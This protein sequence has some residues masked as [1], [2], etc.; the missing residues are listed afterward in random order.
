[1]NRNSKLSK[2][3]KLIITLVIVYFLVTS[4]MKLFSNNNHSDG[5]NSYIENHN[6]SYDTNTDSEVNYETLPEARNKFTKIIGNGNDEVTVMVYMIGTDL[7]SSYGMATTDVWEILNG[8]V[9]DNINVVLQTGGC[10]R[11]NNTVFD[12]RKVERWAINSSNFSRLGTVGSVSMVEP[13]TLSDFIK[14]S[15]DNFPANRYMLILWDHGGG[16]ETG[17]GYDE[18]Y[19]NGSMSPDEIGK[20]LKDSGI[21]FDI[22][23]FDACLMANL[24][25]A[26]AIEPY[27]DYLVASEETEPG[28]G[29]YYTNWVKM[30][31]S[32]TSLPSIT[33]GK[34]IIDDYVSSS[35]KANSKN[36]ITES[37]IDL[38]EL[39]YGIKAPLTKF[40]KA[41][42]DE[43]N[44]NNYQEIAIARSNTKEFSKS[45]NLDQVDLVD[46]ANKINVSGSGEL[47]DAVKSAVKYNKTYNT[48]NSYGLSVYFPYSSLS[49]VNSMVKIY[50]NINMDEDFAGVVKSF[51]TYAS[52]GQIVSH[53]S[54]ST[55]TS[56]F[57]LLLGDSYYSNDDY[58][59][60]NDYYD[61]FDN[62]Y[63]NSY[64]GYS[65]EDSFGYGYNDWMQ[66]SVVDIMSSFFRNNNVINTKSLNIKKKHG[67]RVVSLS[68][69]EWNLIDSITLNTFVDD[70]E[71]YIDLG[72]D[73]T[74][75]WDEDGN[76]IVDSDGS[77]LTI[78]DNFV[79][80]EYVSSIYYDDDT[81][82]L[83]GYIPAYLND[84]R[85]NIIVNYTNEKPYGE[86]LGAKLLYENSD[87]QQKG[88]IQI[89]DGDEITFLCNYYTYDGEFVDEFMLGD[90]LIVKGPL[91]LNNIY[92]DN[93]YVY[94]YCLK[95]IYGNNLWTPKTVVKK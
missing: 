28:E 83:E 95:D 84:D 50:D 54:S 2:I 8:K 81:Y 58:Y 46:L 39:A 43:L 64:G 21:K 1:M 60:D 85:V 71:G 48:N 92:L 70:G 45:S 44:S 51:A 80:Y 7:E 78:N 23:G 59:D 36:E 86:I 88:L 15:A 52:S 26:L 47:I 61:M 35:K 19:P 38:G 73:N 40:S 82:K 4:L 91:E 79:S 63:N 66:P 72:R 65:Y 75:E 3:Y 53:N 87:T 32:N 67:N 6:I 5:S 16:S 93:D 17:Y 56:L 14:Y 89:K 41:T 30:L 18:N 49:K 9:Y 94:A 57:D 90:P 24:E 31:D 74:F 42:L 34:Q 10:K 68:D 13:D 76:L 12:D 62:S 77:W 22:V 20:A 33:I 55:G 11:W 37:M 27:A 29:W 25:T 69:D